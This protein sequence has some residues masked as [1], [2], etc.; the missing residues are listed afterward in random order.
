[1]FTVNRFRKG[2]ARVS[3]P[4]CAIFSLYF[5]VLTVSPYSLNA[6]EQ[7]FS[8]SKRLSCQSGSLAKDEVVV[9]ST[10]CERQEERVRGQIRKLRKKYRGVSRESSLRS[11]IKSK[12]RRKR[13]ILKGITLCTGGTC[14]VK[15]VPPPQDGTL[16]GLTESSCTLLEQD[17]DNSCTATPD[18]RIA[19]MIDTVTEINRLGDLWNCSRAGDESAADEWNGVE[20]FNDLPSCQMVEAKCPGI[21]G[22]SDQRGEE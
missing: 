8:I 15:D 22:E 16:P 6:E 1:M 18:D 20:D 12:I 7:S 17:I 19:C 14:T 11:K 9:S 3:C 5:F 2:G 13:Q 4:L 10:E 21:L